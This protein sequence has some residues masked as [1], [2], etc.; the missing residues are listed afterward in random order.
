MLTAQE[1]RHAMHQGIAAD[2]VASLAEMDSFKR[3]TC[4]IIKTARMQDR[5]FVTRY[6]AFYLQDS[7]EY[8]PA[9]DSFLT[10]GMAKIKSVTQ[11]ERE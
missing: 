4:N 5:D 9:P 1:I 6:V 8:Q 10:K 2:Y 7:A 3:A 11:E